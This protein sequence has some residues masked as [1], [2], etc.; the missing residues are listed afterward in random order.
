MSAV[1]A[2]ALTLAAL[3]AALFSLAACGD[4]AETPSL[5]RDAETPPTAVVV[6]ASPTA[7][8]I[9]T[10]TSTPPKPAPS[11]IPTPAPSPTAAPIQVA[12]TRTPLPTIAPIPTSPP[13]AA[14]PAPT[15][16]PAP[17]HAD[18]DAAPPPERD[19]VD[20]ALRLRGVSPSAAAPAP[21]LAAPMRVG[22]QETFW[23]TNLTDVSSRRASAT[24]LAVSDNAYWFAED[25]AAVSQASLENAAALFEERVRPAVVGAFGDIRKPGLDGDPRLVVLN[26]TLDGAAGYFGSKDAF[27]AAVH[28]R[29]NEREIVY[30]SADLLGMGMDVYMAVLAHELQH[31]I[32]FAHDEGEESWVNE[33]L[34]ELA[35]AI[36]GYPNYLAMAFETRPDTQLNFWGSEPAGNARYYG[37]AG[38]FFA[39]VAQRAGGFG[40]IAPLAREPLDGVE[41]VDKFLRSHGLAF[42]DVFADWTV[43]NYLD[44][45]DSPRYSYPDRDMAIRTERGPTPGAIRRHSLPQFSARYYVW[46]SPGEVGAIRFAGDTT[47]RQV[48]EDCAVGATCWWSGRGD[49]IDSKLTREFDLS[50][51]T[52]ATLEFAIRRDIE[53]G[54]DYGYIQASAD[55]GRT[56]RI[57][58]GLHTT[59]SNPSGNAYGDGY[60]GA[61]GWEGA[62][63]RESV[64]LT[65]F[66]GAPVLIRF[67]YVTDDAVYLDGMLIDDISIPQ[68]AF[69]DEPETPES[70]DAEG[71]SLV[72][73][74]LEQEF[75]VQLIEIDRLSGEFSVSRLDLDERNRAETRPKGLAA[76]DTTVILIVSPATR[77]TIHPAGYTVELVDG[78]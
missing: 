35:V 49:S 66:A 60:T 13:T 38:A 72:G 37:A 28:P 20:L 78:G 47:V 15:A 55:G 69:S 6:R 4:A 56:W 25:A 70:W 53:E 16:V 24:L 30:M 14:S 71:F 50:G 73:A 51:L 26:A 7:A 67:E 41:G 21:S 22:D 61:S 44:D 17:V 9:P 48:G 46:D 64:D 58:K 29:S 42:E 2:F 32:H 33:G 52:E 76:P 11:A 54:W 59:D 27:P 57:L 68:L 18:A 77:G 1:R 31:A 43:A 34:A 19:L 40:G 45:D 75:I 39:Y 63:E 3:F 5:A 36:A 74:P 62:W 8:P 65:P 23:I 12:P 10:A